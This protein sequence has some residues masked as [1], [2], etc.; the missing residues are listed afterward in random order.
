VADRAL[1]LENLLALRDE[2]LVAAVAAGREQSAGSEPDERETSECES[3]T[4]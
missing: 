2:F 1:L 4:L 3:R